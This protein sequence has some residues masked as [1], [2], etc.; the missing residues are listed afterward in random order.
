MA[1]LQ[2]SRNISEGGRM[3]ITM[4]IRTILNSKKLS[5]GCDKINAPVIQKAVPGKPTEEI[6][7]IL[8]QHHDDSS[9]VLNEFAGS[10]L[11]RFLFR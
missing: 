6:P 1:N 3:E 7:A 5:D 2:E 4:G 9:F 8:L 10:D 11:T